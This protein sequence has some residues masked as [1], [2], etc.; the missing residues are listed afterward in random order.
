MSKETLKQA[1][2]NSVVTETV[3][4]ATAVSFER[5][6]KSILRNLFS[7]RSMNSILLKPHKENP[8]V[9]DVTGMVMDVCCVAFYAALQR[10]YHDHSQR[11]T[12][13]LDYLYDKYGFSFY[14]ITGTNGPLLDLTPKHMERILGKERF[15]NLAVVPRRFIFM[16]DDSEE[17]FTPNQHSI[18]PIPAMITE[19]FVFQ[20]SGMFDMGVIML[21]AKNFLAYV[22]VTVEDGEY[23][24]SIKVTGEPLDVCASIVAIMD[25]SM[26]DGKAKDNVLNKFKKDYN[27]DPESVLKHSQVLWN[28]YQEKKQTNDPFKGIAK[29][30]IGSSSEKTVEEIHTFPTEE[31]CTLGFDYAC[32]IGDICVTQVGS[33]IVIVRGPVL[34]VCALLAVFLDLSQSAP[35]ETEQLLNELEVKYSVDRKDIIRTIQLNYVTRRIPGMYRRRAEGINKDLILRHFV[36]KS[37]DD[38]ETELEKKTEAKYDELKEIFINLR[39][40]DI[41]LAEKEKL[42]D[43]FAKM[44]S[45]TMLVIAMEKHFQDT[46]I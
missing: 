18:T 1:I 11:T 24:G 26:S 21:G 8:L 20:E 28:N 15:H 27:L 13:T 31:A 4:F 5:L 33:N 23:S 19:G 25:I 16:D 38:V 7:K 40:K 32:Q 29:K 30:I 6:S 37:D 12:P 45:V 34:R 39:D 10:R 3:T 46:N 42:L 35:A 41:S 22:P 44:T 17:V 9:V 36:Q 2:Y 14:G 43:K